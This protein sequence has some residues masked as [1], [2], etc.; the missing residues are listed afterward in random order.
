M[1]IKH[2]TR[3]AALL[4]VAET[5]NRLRKVAMGHDVPSEWFDVDSLEEIIDLS[6]KAQKY[7]IYGD[8]GPSSLDLDDP[9]SVAWQHIVIRR[10]STDRA[11]FIRLFE[12]IETLKE[13][14]QTTG[15]SARAP[16]WEYDKPVEI[17]PNDDLTVKTL[18]LIV[19]TALNQCDRLKTNRGCF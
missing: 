16:G 2:F 9:I 13:S 14:I 5:C 17:I 18:E 3:R 19:S 1:R 4:S 15:N 11:A 8:I 6:K 12:A 10:H 7:N